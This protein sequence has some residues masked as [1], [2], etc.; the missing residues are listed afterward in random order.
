MR[1][2]RLLA[3]LLVL[4]LAACGTAPSRE[5][6]AGSAAKERQ[7]AAELNVSLG[8]GYLE[9]GQLEIALEKLNRAL[10]LD[11]RLDYAHTV[12]A[13]VYERIGD[14][15]K[16][17]FHYKR[18]VDLSPAKGALL[19]N[20]GTFLCRRGRYAEA[21]ALFERAL[22]DPFYDTPAVAHANRGSCALAWGRDDAAEQHL[23]RAIE[24]QPNL[25]DALLQLAELSAAK[26][27][28][29]RARAFLQ[30]YEALA[31]ASP[32]SLKLA[33]LIE[34]NLGNATAARE[35]RRRLIDEFPDSDLAQQA[36]TEEK[37]P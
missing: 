4:A 9:Q 36:R 30:R 25:P 18:A 31:P 29:F 13:V 37:P 2:E 1:P 24:L 21:D 7:S 27:D 20:Y 8:Q 23:R 16:A 17:G 11:P 22:K 19:N 28:N 14:D 5:G 10:E 26:G 6:R 33:M 3:L 32:A 35:Y 12:I 34:Q 15:E